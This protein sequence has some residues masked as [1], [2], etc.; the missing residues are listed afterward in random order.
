MDIEDTATADE[1]RLDALARDMAAYIR[2]HGAAVDMG[3]AV[4]ELCRLGCSA[5]EAADVIEHGLHTGTLVLLG[6]K[7]KLDAGFTEGRLV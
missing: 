6:S 7:S 2:R 3:I 1:G 4:A 5:E